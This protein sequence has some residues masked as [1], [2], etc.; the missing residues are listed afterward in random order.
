MASPF[1]I[2]RKNQKMWLAAL[3]LL[4]I[5]AFVFLGNTAGSYSGRTVQN[6]VV[7]KTTA[8]GNLRASQ[9]NALLQQRQKVLGVLTDVVQMAG[10][11]ND[12][13]MA[14]PWLEM[15]LGTATEESVVNGWLLAHRAQQ[16][17]MVISDQTI[18][19]F[20]KA[21]TRDVVTP[22]NFQAVFRRYGTS[23]LSVLQRHA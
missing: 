20:L 19:D 6:P 23:G 15:T 13:N 3:T 21:M 4:A 17:G 7:V 11:F 9:V 16:L 5:V 10:L 18:N 2:F 14:R 1:S 12:P 22:A 8:F